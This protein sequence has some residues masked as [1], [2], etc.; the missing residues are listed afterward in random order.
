[1][2]IL[3]RESCFRRNQVLVDR[4]VS[5]IEICMSGRKYDNPGAIYPR[6]FQRRFSVNLWARLARNSM[7]SQVCK[8]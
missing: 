3:C 7:V 4:D 1:M 6:A 5:T 8:K 2:K